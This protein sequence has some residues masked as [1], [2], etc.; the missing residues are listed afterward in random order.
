MSRTC[1][2][3]FVM[4]LMFAYKMCDRHILVCAHIYLCVPEHPSVRKQFTAYR[5]IA[6]FSVRAHTTVMVDTGGGKLCKFA[7]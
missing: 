7:W 5:Y 6:F 2:D 4:R 1:P 3:A